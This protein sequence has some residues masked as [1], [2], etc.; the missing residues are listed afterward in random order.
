MS[1]PGSLTQG[2]LVG[3]LLVGGLGVILLPGI[4]RPGAM[5]PCCA[6]ASPSGAGAGAPSES[7]RNAPTC[8]TGNNELPERTLRTVAE[9]VDALEHCFATPLGSQTRV[10][11]KPLSPLVEARARWSG[12]DSSGAMLNSWSA[13]FPVGATQG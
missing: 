1:L 5:R 2:P 6:R 3:K 13:E 8:S 10:C 11:C 7:P 9:V 12:L 4:L